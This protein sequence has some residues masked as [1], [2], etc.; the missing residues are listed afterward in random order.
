MATNLS[1]M[2]S[3][4][5]VGWAAPTLDRARLLTE[6]TFAREV[7]DTWLALGLPEAEADA[8]CEALSVYE[9]RDSEEVLHEVRREYTWL[10]MLERRVEN[11]EGP[12]R[13]K[14]AGHEQV[15]YM[16]NDISMGIQ[17]F[18][19]SCGVVRPKGYNESVD[20]IDNEWEFC[21]I[22]AEDPAYMAEQGVSPE[23]KL[24]QFIDE[25][26]RVW[27]PGFSE[28]VVAASRIPYYRALAELQGKLVEEL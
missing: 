1:N 18:M 20:R 28:Q 19:A 23:E 15:L 25:H 17:D 14:D 2:F 26:V 24:T 5:S 3:L 10:F 7:R 11:T 21:R 8:F 16:V 22:L 4:L 6:G 12:W 27:V 13:K 9:G